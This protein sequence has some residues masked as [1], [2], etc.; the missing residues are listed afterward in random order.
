METKSRK[1]SATKAVED[2]LDQSSQKLFNRFDHKAL[3]K[4]SIKF[5]TAL[6]SSAAVERAF[7][8]GKDIPKPKRSGLS[9]SYFEKLL[10][11]KVNL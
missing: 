8:I 6:P 5:N 4:L 7:S 9:D 3:K 2:F 11:L 1:Q 10:F